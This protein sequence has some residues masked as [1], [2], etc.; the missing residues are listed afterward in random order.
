MNCRHKDIIFFLHIQQ[1]YVK[2]KK[3]THIIYFILRLN[4]IINLY[5][6][7]IHFAYIKN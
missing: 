5:F 1:K 6:T 3:K 2:K 7:L 4:Y